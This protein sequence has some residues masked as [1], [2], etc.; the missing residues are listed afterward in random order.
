VFSSKDAVA[1]VRETVGQLAS[2]DSGTTDRARQ[3]VSTLL[4]EMENLN[5]L[6]N[7]GMREVSSAGDQ[8]RDAVG[9]AVRCLQF[10]D[11]ATQALGSAIRHAGRI[12]AVGAEA[13][14]MQ[15]GMPVASAPSVAA[16]SAPAVAAPMMAA[17]A[18]ASVPV[19]AA[20]SAPIMFS[21]P[22]PIATQPVAASHNGA[23][24]HDV[25]DWRTPVHKP[26]AQE[27]MQA[28]AVELF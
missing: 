4:H 26:V 19:A 25:M 20:A 17:A 8:I 5:S 23:N 1:Q 18:M 21:A 13:G 2:R 24:G 16:Y 11:I 9:Q 28:G 14:R 12:D 10:E 3:E 7:D 22:T 6:L 27:N 15:A